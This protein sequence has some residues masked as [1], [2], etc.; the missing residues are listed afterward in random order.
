MIIAV[1]GPAA[2]G[3]GTLAK[4]L[5]RHFGF[6]YLDTG[7]LYRGVALAV[8]NAGDTPEDEVAALRAA[9]GLRAPDLDPSL[10][11]GDEVAKAA[12]R[13]AAIP[14]VRATLLAFQR[15][16][17]NAPPDSAPGAVIDGRDIGT[18]VCPDAPAKMFVTASTEVRAR[19]RHKELLQNGVKSIYAKVLQD[20]RDRDARDA[21][22][23]TA[24]MKAADDA[25][26]LDT[27]DL[28]ADAAFAVA[29]DYLNSRLKP[30][31]GG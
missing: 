4:R 10:L 11:R 14:A 21:R 7:L 5:A 19:R 17:A 9:R 18:V 1:D 27:T 30:N 13:V 28:D 15:R 25:F 16:F 31:A 6:A 26:L 8:L 29:L 2:S 23:A 3:K 20:L 12:S 22:R 24:P